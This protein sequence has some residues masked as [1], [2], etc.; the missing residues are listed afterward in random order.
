MAYMMTFFKWIYLIDLTTILKIIL[1]RKL[2]KVLE[3]LCKDIPVI[4]D[5][6]SDKNSTD[7]NNA[8]DYDNPRL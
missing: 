8:S 4:F 5:S 2:K 1:P 3:N 6:S 7:Y